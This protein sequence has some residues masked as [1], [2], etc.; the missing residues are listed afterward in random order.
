MTLAFESL[1]LQIAL[2]KCNNEPF[3]PKFSELEGKSSYFL[4][5]KVKLGITN[6]QT[7]IEYIGKY[8]MFWEDGIGI[9][10]LLFA[11]FKH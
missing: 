11:K 5:T 7:P 10:S 2:Q 9:E 1:T 3:V 8:Q 6:C 4:I